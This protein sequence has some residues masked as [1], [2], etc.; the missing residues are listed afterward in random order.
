MA[1]TRIGLVDPS[2]HFQLLHMPAEVW[3]P[4][5]GFLRLLQHALPQVKG[6][7]RRL[8]A[9]FPARPSESAHVRIA[10]M[11]LPFVGSVF[12]MAPCE[13]DFSIPSVDNQTAAEIFTAGSEPAK[14]GS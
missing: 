4:A 2:A 7:S 11:G 9:P 8:R 13:W 3:Q 1:T 14:Y 10:S 12:P 6:R 5:A